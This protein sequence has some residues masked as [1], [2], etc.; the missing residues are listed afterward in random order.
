MKVSR[1]GHEYVKMKTAN[2]KLDIQ[3]SES[4]R[5]PYQN[6]ANY[7]SRIRAQSDTKAAQ[8]KIRVISTTA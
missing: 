4:T 5:R 1:K 3:D 6:N 2:W 7:Q 8:K